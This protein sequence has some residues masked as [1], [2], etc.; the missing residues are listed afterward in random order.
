M[1]ELRSRLL[2]SIS[3]SLHP[4]QPVGASPLGTRRIIPISGG[5]FEG[6]RLRGIV[7]PH[8][9]ADWLLD[10]ADGSSQ[11]DA[12]L[13]LQT[14]DG[15]LIFMSYRGVRLVSPEVSARIARGERVDAS[16]YYQRIAPFFETASERYGWL[17]RIVSVGVG[18][19][20]PGGVSYR[21]FEVL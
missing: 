18:E 4:I 11:Q 6:E 5:S 13:T 20:T 3:L 17:N 2:F 10:R 19:R 14:D 8:A 1:S 7:L 21:V 12:R 16:E 9:A 15:V